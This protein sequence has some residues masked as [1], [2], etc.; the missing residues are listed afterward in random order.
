MH[1]MLEGIVAGICNANDKWRVQRSAG[2]GVP[3]CVYA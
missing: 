1:S 3:A 2:D